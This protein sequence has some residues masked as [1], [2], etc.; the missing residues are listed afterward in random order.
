MFIQ[1]KHMTDKPM[2]YER[3]NRIC[4][5]NASKLS[6]YHVEEL[7][8]LACVEKTGWVQFEPMTL[9]ISGTSFRINGVDCKFD[10]YFGNQ[11]AFDILGFKVLRKTG[12]PLGYSAWLRNQ[13]CV[14]S[15]WIT[16]VLRLI[17]IMG[18]IFPFVEL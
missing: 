15:A 6:D 14:H 7:K 10:V 13:R 17:S 16:T 11:A 18:V 4:I 8:S 9:G 5:Q 2:G 12:E 1:L 3:D